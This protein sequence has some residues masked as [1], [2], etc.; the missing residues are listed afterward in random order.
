[1]VYEQICNLINEGQAVIATKWSSTE[2]IM[3]PA[4]NSDLYTAWRSKTLSILDMFPEH[5][6]SRFIK[7]IEEKKSNSYSNATQ[8]LESLK[9]IKE[10]IDQNVI[11][12]NHDK[13]TKHEPLESVKLICTRFHKVARSLKNRHNNRT[14][15]I[16]NDEYDVQDLFGSLLKLFFDDVRAEEYVPS[17][18]GGASRTD[19]L[20]PNEGLVIEIKKTRESMKETNLGE[21]LIID[22]ERYRAHPECRY[23]VCFVYDPEEI[24][25]NPDGIMRDLNAEHDG[26]AIVIIEP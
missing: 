2:V 7:D 21:Q 10:L 3:A 12:L 6:V 11:P 19:F 18:A 9:A 22:L 4:V 13:P 1:M 8:I 17:Y 15:L 26:E 20:L 16:I 25:V 24:L 14:T 5:S 23:I